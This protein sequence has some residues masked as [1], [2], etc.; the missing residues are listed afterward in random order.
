MDLEQTIEV[1]GL[2]PL[3][4]MIGLT[5][6]AVDRWRTNGVPLEHCAA[7]ELATNRIFLRRDARPNDWYRI[8]PELLITVDSVK[9]ARGRV[10]RTA[11][12][13]PANAATELQAA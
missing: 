5:P 7:L 10:R 6:Q 11:G 8:W 2:T 9:A 13:A 3:A 12:A 1:F 4:R